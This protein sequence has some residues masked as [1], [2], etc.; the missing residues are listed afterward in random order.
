L[1]APVSA[2]AGA[3][4]AAGPFLAAVLAVGLLACFLAVW[5]CAGDISVMA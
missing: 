2:L 4:L 1:E 5:A 3:G